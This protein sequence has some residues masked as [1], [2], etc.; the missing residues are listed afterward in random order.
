MRVRE[1]DWKKLVP[2]TTGHKI[3]IAGT[4]VEGAVDIYAPPGSAVLAPADGWVVDSMYLKSPLFGYQIRGYVIDR[5]DRKMGFVIAH[6]LKD[7]F[8]Q[9]GDAIVQGQQIGR[10]ALWPEHPASSH[11]HFSFRVGDSFGGPT[12]PP[13]GNIKIVRALRRCGI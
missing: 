13:P 12:L 11:A 6:L 7:T 2:R 4:F 3:H 8:P 9:P 5:E 10:V 1:P